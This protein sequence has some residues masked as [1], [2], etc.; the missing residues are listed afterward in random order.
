MAIDPSIAL[1]YKG[2]EAPNPLAQYAQVSQIQNAQNQNALAQFQMRAAQRGE[3]D[4]EAMRNALAGV[5]YGTPEYDQALTG[6]FLKTGNVKGLQ[7]HQKGQREN[8]KAAAELA[9]KQQE[10]K[11]GIFSNLA[12]NPSD[13]NVK[14]HLQD[15]LIQKQMSQQEADSWLAKVGPMSPAQ[16]KAL[17]DNLAQTADQRTGHEVAI[18][19]QDLVNQRAKDR[20]AAETASGDLSPQTIDFVAE[21]YRQTGQLPPLGMGKAAVN[22]RQKVLER[23]AQ[24]SMGNG[25]TAKTA[26]EAAADVKTAKNENA[27]AAAGQ[28]TLGTQI[29]NVQIAAKEANKMIDVARPYVDKVDPTDYPA[30]NAAGN[31]VARNTGDPNIVGLATS[32]NGLVNTYARAISPKGVATVSDKNHA[33]EIINAAMSKGQI[34]EAFKVMGQEMD[35]A[36]AS[37]PET[38]AA[39]RPQAATPAAVPPAAVQL[40]QANPSLAAAFDQKYGA[41]AAKRAL[42]Q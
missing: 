16:R 19:G 42:G 23:A 21:I 2:F 18:R 34:N 11:R 1:G 25:D 13:E 22:M 26:A 9:L 14:S 10:L 30:L 38:R 4:T 12:M 31:F 15:L 37:G 29:A 24:L 17:F 27:G 5:Q 6:A 36:L 3:Q 33:R 39:M 28:R 40:L 41:G 32:L 35:A 20:L 7:E 8:D